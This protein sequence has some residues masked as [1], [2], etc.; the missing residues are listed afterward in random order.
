MLTGQRHPSAWKTQCLSG[1]RIVVS[2]RKT[3]KCWETRLL[4]M[5][6]VAKSLASAEPKSLLL[7]NHILR[8][9]MRCF[10]PSVAWCG[11]G[12]KIAP[13]CSVFPVLRPMGPSPSTRSGWPLILR[14][15]RGLQFS[16]CGAFYG[17]TAR[18]SRPTMGRHQLRHLISMWC[19][20]II[21]SVLLMTA[22]GTS[23]CLMS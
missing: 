7:G 4:N 13:T 16:G 3:M 23:I 11:P 10:T 22:I 21:V 19:I 8:R 18:T 15:I 20:A 14:A 2:L 5:M 1:L 9:W 6:S 17:P 12:C